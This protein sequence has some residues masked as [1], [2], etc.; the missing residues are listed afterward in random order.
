MAI[1]CNMKK[2][3]EFHKSWKYLQ[4]SPT[5]TIVGA[6]SNLKEKSVS[7]STTLLMK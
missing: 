7:L 1:T 4:D 2:K 3:E 6:S 5:S